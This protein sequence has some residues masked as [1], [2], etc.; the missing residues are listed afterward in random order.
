MTDR[1]RLLIAVLSEVDDYDRLGEV[2]VLELVA[3]LYE[4]GNEQHRFGR[5]QRVTATV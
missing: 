4:L 1:E 5:Q 3:M 2:T